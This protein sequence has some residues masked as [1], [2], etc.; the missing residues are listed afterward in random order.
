[1]AGDPAHAAK[2][3]DSP[4]TASRR[5]RCGELFA[6]DPDEVP[7]F[8]EFV[9]GFLA[10]C[11]MKNKPSEVQTKESIFRWHLLPA[12]GPVLR[13]LLVVAKK[14]ELIEAVPEIEWLKAPKPDSTSSPSTRRRGSWPRPT[15]SGPA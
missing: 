15:Q 6:D 1:M 7:T 14:R 11:R 4:S 8:E 9:P 5:A 3:T 12:F 13:R 10:I 2:P